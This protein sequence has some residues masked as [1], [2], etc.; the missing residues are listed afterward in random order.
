MKSLEGK[1]A[2]VTGGS[3]GIGKSISLK[4][5][6][7][8]AKVVVSYTSH[9]DAAREVVS[10]I[11][12]MGGQAIGVQGDLRRL[13]AAGEIVAA[14]IQRF[15]RLDI[16]VNNAALAILQALESTEMEMF[17]S[18]VDLNMRAPLALVQRALPHLSEGGR[19]I[20][21]SSLAAQ[22]VL[23]MSSVYAAT[24]AGLE[25]M[26]RVWALE[27]APR[28]ITVNAVAPGPVMT[29]AL[30]DAQSPEALEYMVKATP[31]GRI[32]E[33]EDVSDIVA[34]LASEASRWVTGHTIRATGGFGG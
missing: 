23:P 21:V 20:N 14:T 19:I 3:R 17:S 13:E 27:L 24:K 31:L 18:L 4:L 2:I 32:G 1:V 12:V 8:G 5:A 30:R 28:K 11:E 29:D 16:L 7:E 6:S 15:G 9:A 25:A 10:A 22:V 34:F 33:P 26:T